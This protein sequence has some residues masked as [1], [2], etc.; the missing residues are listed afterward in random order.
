MDERSQRMGQRI[1]EI[2]KGKG[3]SLQ[4][5]AG[6]IGVTRQQMGRLE[7]GARTLKPDVMEQIARAL[8]VSLA[9]IE[10]ESDTASWVADLLRLLG[11]DVLLREM[12]R[13]AHGHS[14]AADVVASLR[15]GP[16]QLKVAVLCRN[17]A[18]VQDLQ[19]LQ[20]FVDRS[21]VHMGLVVTEVM[22][23][24]DVMDYAERRGVAVVRRQ[25]LL[26]QL[27][28]LRGYAKELIDRWN[29][30]AL[31]YV[32]PACEPVDDGGSQPLSTFLDAWLQQDAI[33]HLVLLGE[34][35]VG[36]STVCKHLAAT[37]AQRHIDE[38]GT[39]PVPLLV[40]LWEFPYVN[41][42]KQLVFKELYFKHGAFISGVGALERML[43]EGRFVLIL[44]GF[45]EMTV[46]LDPFVVRRNLRAIA[47][48]LDC[49]SRIL[50]TARTRVFRD[51][52][53]IT[54]VLVPPG[55]WEQDLRSTDLPP[56][57]VA[58]LEEFDRGRIESYLRGHSARGW[59]GTLARIEALD[60]WDV[61]RFP[62][63]LRLMTPFLT[64]LGAAGSW[65]R[66]L[67]SL[68]DQAVDRWAQQEAVRFCVPK[69]DL[70]RLLEEMAYLLW[71]MDQPTVNVRQLPAGLADLLSGGGDPP[72]GRFPAGEA[73]GSSLFVEWD[74]QG[75]YRF[76]HR[77]FQDYLLLRRLFRGIQ[78]G[79]GE[80]FEQFWFND[81]T[82]R[83]AAGLVEDTG[84]RDRLSEWLTSHESA[85]VRSVAAYLL[86]LTRASAVEGVLQEAAAREDDVAVRS[87]A[88]YSLARLGALDVVTDL[89]TLARAGAEP[90]RQLDARITLLLLANEHWEADEEDTRE[91]IAGEIRGWS[92]EDVCTELPRL[93]ED[94]ET[95]EAD[96][97]ALVRVAGFVG[98]SV[99]QASLDVLLT[100]PS[101]RVRA[102][103][104]AGLME[105]ERRL[106]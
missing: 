13:D 103:A 45:D 89:G 70:I 22:P 85:S 92:A 60:L 88:A 65:P 25:E 47:G 15:T 79:D 50:M 106:G 100:H 87:A 86:G 51:P 29:N 52:S 93:L 80:E 39:Q 48:L 1:R 12:V 84:V 57:R 16:L 56:V 102:A 73:M 71:Q 8:H 96:M 82:A 41:D 34:P 32:E 69:S 77:T 17:A 21:Q 42:L 14:F 10:V 23:G 30:L 31:R 44:D 38:P 105:M 94:P 7:S 55:R 64:G 61:A 4:Q 59:R 66:T 67:T 46:R 26:N 98:D 49:G 101:R 19:Q 33:S 24:P 83:L 9:S 20:D 28:D 2:R 62:L 6:D 104:R 90:R 11:Y 81:V 53:E 74:R 91:A 3:L 97:A 36:K 54:E 43:A 58:R 72:P 35:G 18:L 99:V 27:V 37:L 75:N 76:V 63:A 40:P 68:L 5:L 95:P 78:E